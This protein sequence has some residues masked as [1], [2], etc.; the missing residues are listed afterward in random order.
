MVAGGR[1]LVRQVVDVLTSVAR[2]AATVQD[3]LQRRV[4]PVALSGLAPVVPSAP[5]V[6]SFGGFKER[7][8]FAPPLCSAVAIA[9]DLRTP[10]VDSRSFWLLGAGAALAVGAPTL[11]LLRW[12]NRGGS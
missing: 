8:A 3:R 5:L 4:V 2:G 7:R 12:Q 1:S 6:G 11:G 9:D 10:V